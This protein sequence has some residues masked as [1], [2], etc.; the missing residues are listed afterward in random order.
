MMKLEAA[1]LA[2][3]L[4]FFAAAPSGADGENTGI[5]PETTGVETTAPVSAAPPLRVIYKP[6]AAGKPARSVGGGS[7]GTIDKIPG[8]FAVTPDH[9]GRTI[10][11]QP[12]LF[13][14]IDRAPDPSMQVEFTLLDEDGIEPL[15]ETTLPTPDRAGVH[16]IRLSDFDVK[17]VYGREYEW[18]VAL[19]V[20]PEKRSKD[21]V[22][23]GWID[24]VEGSDELAARVASGGSQASAAIYAEEGLWY[25]SFSALSD[26][27]ESDPSDDQLVQQRQDVLRQVGLEVA[28]AGTDG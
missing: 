7:R 15:I 23:T 18:S 19:I 16:R 5:A 27:I 6:P 10:S 21:I 28:A 3:A 4:A 9:V 25:D 1:A 11:A 22:A 8:L 20:D 2:V 12:S 14:F 24:R 13:W 26:L 17:L